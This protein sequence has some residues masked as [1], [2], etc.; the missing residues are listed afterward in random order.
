MPALHPARIENKALYWKSRV[1]PPIQVCFFS[2]A[3]HS[4]LRSIFTLWLSYPGLGSSSASFEVDEVEVCLI[5]FPPVHYADAGQSPP[6][7]EDDPVEEESSN[8]IY[9]RH[10]YLKKHGFPLW[11]PQPNTTLPQSYQRRGVSIGDVGIFTSNGGFDF[12]FNICLP[13]GDTS[14]PDELPEGFSHLELKETDV[15]KFHAH[16]S[17]SHFASPDV[18]KRE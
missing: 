16:S 7:E 4:K 10:M 6:T 8:S 17:H 13:A 14:N 18:K 12:L 11:I 1:C 9:E 5:S 15:C 2:R 3:F